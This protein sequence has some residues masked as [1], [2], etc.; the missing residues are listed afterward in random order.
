MGGSPGWRKIWSRMKAGGKDIVAS[1]NLRTVAVVLFVTY[2]C[3]QAFNMFWSPLV[4]EL[5][6]S[7]ELSIPIT[8]PALEQGFGGIYIAILWSLS[9]FFFALGSSLIKNKSTIGLRGAGILL[10]M[11]GVTIGGFCMVSSFVSDIKALFLVSF[12]FLFHEIWRGAFMEVIYTY[13][14]RSIYESRRATVNSR[15]GAVVT[16]AAALGLLVSG[17]LGDLIPLLWVWIISACGLILL[18]GLT[19]YWS[20]DLDK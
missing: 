4:A 16:F 11:T 7:S 20:S 1:R 6:E 14:N 2:F 9:M 13:R 17:A 12:G 3:F 19:I 15:C 18:G 8:I 5:L 10:T